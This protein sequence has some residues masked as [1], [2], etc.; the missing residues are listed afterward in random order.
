MLN[1]IIAIL[2]TFLTRQNIYH[3]ERL[4]PRG[5]LRRHLVAAITGICRLRERG[6]D[7]G[8]QEGS[9]PKAAT[10]VA[11]PASRIPWISSVGLPG[12]AA[13]A[14][15]PDSAR[16]WASSS[17]IRL[18]NAPISSLRPWKDNQLTISTLTRCISWWYHSRSI[19]AGREKRISGEL[20]LSRRY[21]SSETSKK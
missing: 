5:L 7:R 19:L 6:L 14:K 16:F 11:G 10:R 17:R 18:C 21:S 13:C 3:N 9:R 12:L 4:I 15:S 1:L 2:S 20:I 8:T